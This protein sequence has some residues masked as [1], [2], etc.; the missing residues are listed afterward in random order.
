MAARYLDCGKPYMPAASLKEPVSHA[1]DTPL[2]EFTA[3]RVRNVKLRHAL[4]SAGNGQ[5]KF[6]CD[7]DDFMVHVLRLLG[8]AVD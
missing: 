7:D 6:D 3:L 4:K 2:P 5:D 1:L 8:A